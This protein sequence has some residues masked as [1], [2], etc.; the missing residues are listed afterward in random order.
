MKWVWMGMAVTCFVLGTGEAPE[1]N[2]H[3]KPQDQGV[4]QENSTSKSE[5]R[6]SRSEDAS[7][8]QDADKNALGLPLVKHL[9]SDQKTIWT[10]PARIRLEDATWLVPLGGFT[11][12]LLATDRDASLHLSNNP[13]TLKHYDNLSN[14]GIASMV[15]GTGALYLWG[16]ITH[17]DLHRETGLLAG[18]AALNSLGVTYAMK[19][20]FGRERPLEDN[21]DGKF[22]K[23]GDSF[24]S[25]HAAVAWSIAAI[26]THEYPGPL[27]KLLALGAA[28][29]ISFARVKSKQHFPSDAL[30]GT[31]I[32]W[33]DGWQ[34]YTSHHD[35]ELGGTT[36]SS[37]AEHFFTDRPYQAKNMGSPSVPLDSWVYPALDRLAALG[38]VTSDMRGMRPWTRME[39]ARLV[40]EA[41]DHLADDPSDAGGAQGLYSALEK[42]F[43]REIDRWSG[44]ENR[45]IR[46][47]SVYARATEIS[48]QPLRDGY[49]F[50]QTIINDYGRP[51]AEGWNDIE[52]FS[53][54]ASDGPFFGYL[55]G[56]YQSAPSS[57]ALPDA[58]RQAIQNEED[59]PTEPP[60]TPIPAVSKFDPLE[61]Y[62]GMQ[63]ENWQISFGK[64]AEW[65][66]P[67]V[68]GAM[69]F[70]TNAEPIKMLRINTTSPFDLPSVFGYAIPVR[71]EFFLGRLEGQHWV[72]SVNSG[73]TGSWTQPFSDQPFISGG[74]V[75]FKPSPNLELGISATALF[76]GSGMPFTP[77]ALW[78]AFFSFETGP[79]G[80]STFPGDRRGEF[81]FTYR[82][83]KLRHGLTWY[84]DAFTEDE[85][86]PWIAWDKATLT[87]G[88]YMPRIPKIPKLD[89]RVE[90]VFTDLPGGRPGL[91]NTTGL[92][93]SFYWN[94][95]Y[96]SGYTNNGNL[97]GSW[98]GRE[99]QGAQAWAT[100]WFSPKN[101]L[102]LYFRHQKV[103][104]ELIPDGGTLTDA[105]VTADFWVHAAFNVSTTVQYENWDYPVISST[106]QSNVSASIQFTFWPGTWLSKAGASR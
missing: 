26:V 44:G 38:Y 45:E 18:E 99:G 40:E 61:A 90:G 59:L 29:A 37:P 30:V 70:S 5:S 82:I 2:C 75:S 64:Q 4:A 69:L 17:N 88:L 13:T 97:I 12:G 93:G 22:W 86:N 83:P 20:A 85:V 62:V 35:P 104:Q 41:A 48:G 36:W 87:S 56:E 54:W 28:S 65:W 24:P 74:K 92:D 101:K 14:Y 1:M 39:C 53:G 11:A 33:L 98:I 27:P 91:L 23:G 6:E 52:G 81:D 19:Y 31:G 66:G 71:A 50:G 25:E 95:R 47:E 72:Y 102:Q 80:S 3:A 94:D 58:A 89:L 78:R 46:L 34:V 68:G 32:G 51:Y 96:R 16:H 10:S 43:S 42:E 106:P 84:A 105:G 8:P 49:D 67:G 73:Y 103:S 63:L 77:R 79:P 100:Y 60:D 7:S 21:F 15:G 55:R 76:A 9:L 57:P